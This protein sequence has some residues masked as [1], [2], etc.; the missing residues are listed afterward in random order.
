MLEI[1]A[2]A[3]HMV[4]QLEIRDISLLPYLHENDASDVSK[5]ILAG[6]R[7]GLVNCLASRNVPKVRNDQDC[8]THAIALEGLQIGDYCDPHGQDVLPHNLRQHCHQDLTHHLTE[9]I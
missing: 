5:C 8:Q 6:P 1:F 2:A 9:L 4:W 7:G 3:L